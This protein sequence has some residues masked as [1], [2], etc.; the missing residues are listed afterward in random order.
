MGFSSLQAHALSLPLPI[1]NI[2][3]IKKNVY[4]N[5]YSTVLAHRKYSKMPIDAQVITSVIFSY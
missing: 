1:L 2:A 4:D 5:P 3:I